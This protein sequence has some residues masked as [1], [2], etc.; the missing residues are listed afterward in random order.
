MPL[1]CW[2]WEHLGLFLVSL[3]FLMLATLGAQQL[4]HRF[5]HATHALP[6]M[7][8]WGVGNQEG[9]IVNRCTSR[10]AKMAMTMRI[11]SDARARES[12]SKVGKDH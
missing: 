9:L 11:D 5:L 7:N 6:A 2:E 1:E 12:N 8:H 3:T 4:R 10:S